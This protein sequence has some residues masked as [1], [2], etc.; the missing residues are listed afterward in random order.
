MKKLVL[1]ALTLAFFATSAQAVTFRLGDHPDGNLSSTS[2]YGIRL[3]AFGGRLISADGLILTVNQTDATISGQTTDQNN[4]EYTISASFSIDLLNADGEF[5][6]TGGNVRILQT[7]G[8]IFDETLAITSSGGN[9]FIFRF[10]GHRLAGFPGFDDNSPV[11]RGWIEPGNG[12]T[13]CCNDFLVTAT[14]VPV[15]AAVWLFGS[16]LAGLIAVRR[17]RAGVVNA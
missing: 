11:G 3:D 13:G 5:E 4:N 12:Y 6:A 8:G 15:P 7:S 1:A 17:R 10:D 9:P 2:P 16:A 14:V